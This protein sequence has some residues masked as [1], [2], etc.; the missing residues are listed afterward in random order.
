MDAISGKMSERTNSR[1]RMCGSAPLASKI[2]GFRSQAIRLACICPKGSKR[3]AGGN[4]IEHAL[5]EERAHSE[6]GVDRKNPERVPKSDG[7]MQFFHI[8]ERRTAR[9]WDAARLQARQ[10]GGPWSDWLHAIPEPA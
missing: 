6:I 9:G 3:C 4:D 7:M 8:R 1:K 2:A 5:V 10:S